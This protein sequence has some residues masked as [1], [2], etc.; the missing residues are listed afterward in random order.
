MSN[1]PST[2]T[3]D[4][5]R[6]D[7]APRSPSRSQIALRS[8]ALGLSSVVMAALLAWLL[9]RVLG[10]TSHAE[11]RFPVAFLIT[12]PLLVIGSAA[13][14]LAR[15]AVQR[16]RQARFRLWLHRSLVIGII[17]MGVQTYALWTIIPPERTSDGASTGVAPL[18]LALAALHG[19]HF[20]VAS[21]FLA[22]VVVQAEAGRY[23]H[24]YYWGV[25]VCASFWHALG[26][27]WG[28]ILA[29]YSIVAW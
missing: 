24:E 6:H 2:S 29:V 10:R 20:L 1:V 19:L 23:D 4:Y 18:V 15:R 12:T 17:F 22:Y 25:S 11:F 28:A 16:E 8:F 13:L 21:W 3:N 26:I 27:A 7:A 9:A 5:W 14:S